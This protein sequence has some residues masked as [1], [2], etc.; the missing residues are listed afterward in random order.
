MIATARWRLG[1]LLSFAA[2]AVAV[3]ALVGVRH[4][5]GSYL[6]QW[7]VV[8]QG[9]INPWGSL[10]NNTPGNAYG[11][12]HNALAIPYALHPLA[13]KFIE[14]LLLLAAMLLIFVRLQQ[15]SVSLAAWIVFALA[16]PTNMTLWFFGIAYGDN[17]SL[18]GALVG[19]ATLARMDGRTAVAGALLGAA[20][21]V[22]FYPLALAPL[23]AI[24]GR[25][26]VT[27]SLPLAAA[28]T[29][30]AGMV[31]GYLFWGPWIFDPLAFAGNRPPTFQS[32]MVPLSHLGRLIGL[33]DAVSS[34]NSAFVL[35]MLAGFGIWAWLTGVQWLAAATIGYLAMMLAYK[36]GHQQF[37][38]P[39]LLMVGCLPLLPNP[40]GRQLALAALPYVI[41]LSLAGI[42]PTP[43]ADFWTLAMPI[44]PFFSFAAGLITLFAL[45]RA[46]DATSNGDPSAIGRP[47]AYVTSRR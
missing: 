2:L 22:K 1:G 35:V 3:S 34:A 36:V 26:R 46:Q 16:V 39:W 13:P 7:Q 45:W 14:L 44:V 29:F 38:I 8:L 30:G 47:A 11:P 32:I 20:G 41:Y 28:A 25:R 27:W 37:F 4:D 10:P 33:G 42:W 12:L 24:E 23:F 5:Y 18:V 21:L 43:R 17:D 40:F 19:L 6:V 9:E 31:A 15:A